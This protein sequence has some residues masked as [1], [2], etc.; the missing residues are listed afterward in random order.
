MSRVVTCLLLRV[1]VVVSDVALSGA[2]LQRLSW[3]THSPGLDISQLQRATIQTMVN[4][5]ETRLLLREHLLVGD[6][7][8]VPGLLLQQ[9][10]HFL[11]L[12]GHGCCALCLLTLEHIHLYRSCVA[13]ND[14][15]LGLPNFGIGTKKILFMQRMR[16]CEYLLELPLVLMSS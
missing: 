14:T 12:S 7:G 11:L 3:K 13:L 9:V 4:M 6:A 8:P 16:P 2:L 1:Q 15:R 5:V 10:H